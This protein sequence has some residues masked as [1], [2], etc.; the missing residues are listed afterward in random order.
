MASSF[1]RRFLPAVRKRG[2]ILRGFSKKLGLV[3]FGR[4]DQHVDDHE[5]IRGL[6]TSITHQD[7]HY[8]VGSYDGY[9]IAIVDRI[10]QISDAKGASEAAQWLILEVRL[11]Q[12]NEIPHLFLQPLDG[13]ESLYRNS[14]SALRHLQLI[15]DLFGDNYA[16][17]FHRRYQIYAAA[18]HNMTIEEYF[19]PLVTQTIAARFWP[20]AIEVFEDK[21][22]LYYSEA[23][24]G[25]KQLESLIDS[26]LWLAQTLDERGEARA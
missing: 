9:D 5:A 11:T 23:S 22:Y 26:A 14:L 20:V 16:D 17:E 10:D 13:K 2:A 15:N 12:P 24:L 18:T 4:V 8:A 7:E 21:L 19:T 6:T 3:Y 1:F 25:Q